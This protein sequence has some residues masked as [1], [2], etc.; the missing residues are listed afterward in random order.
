M[1]TDWLKADWPAPPGVVAGTTLRSGGVSEGPFASLNLAAHVGDQSGH[2]AAN[3]RR[4]LKECALPA[5]PTWLSQVHGSTVCVDTK[6]ANP[7][8]EADAMLCR[9]KGAVA[10][11]LTADCL[12]V[13][14]ASTADDEVAAAHAG[15]RGLAAGVLEN[16]VLA[17]QSPAE[18]IIAWLGPAISQLA[19]EVGSEV[20]EQF[21]D[22]EPAA[23]AHFL[24]NDRGRWQAD[25]YGLA[26]QRLAAAGVLRIYGGGLCTYADSA[27]F[28]SYRRDGECGRMCSFV[29]RNA[30]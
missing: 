21:C 1:M 29:F 17:M 3:R 7:S 28:F 22:L 8:L 5:E 14:F 2:V 15:W 20:R 6:P 12:P 25:L 4:F 10:A 11:V 26:R 19:F 9:E 23:A 24:R 13:L 18:R 27:R 30:A 16:T